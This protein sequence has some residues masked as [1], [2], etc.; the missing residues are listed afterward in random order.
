MWSFKL[1]EDLPIRNDS[2][3]GGTVNSHPLGP[4]LVIENLTENFLTLNGPE[5]P[6]QISYVP[7]SV[8][9]S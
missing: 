3:C 2:D 7:V 1:S 5:I 8:T 9:E 6:E 4:R